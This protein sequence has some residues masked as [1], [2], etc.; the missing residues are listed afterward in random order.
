M[1][2]LFL[3][4]LILFSFFSS[5]AFACKQISKTLETIDYVYY[6]TQSNTYYAITVSDT[7]GSFWVLDIMQSDKEDQKVLKH[8]NDRFRGLNV[9]IEYTGNLNIID[10]VDIVSFEFINH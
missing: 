10:Y 8:L 1:K 5:Q 9:I 3:I 6:D 7:S 2:K 4:S